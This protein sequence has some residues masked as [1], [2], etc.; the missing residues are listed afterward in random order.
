MNSQAVLSTFKMQ[1]PELG[2]SRDQV[3]GIHI[4]TIE[5]DDSGETRGGLTLLITG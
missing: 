2:L 1:A 3:A 4:Q 5:M